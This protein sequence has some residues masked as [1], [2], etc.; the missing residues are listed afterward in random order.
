MNDAIILVY[1]S[2]SDFGT[3]CFA[4]A[5]VDNGIALIEDLYVD[6]GSELFILVTSKTGS[7]DYTLT[8]DGLDCN[9]VPAPTG[10]TA[11][12][13][14]AGDFLSSLQVDG[15]VYNQGFTW[16]S[17]AALTNEIIDPDTELL[18]D[19]TTYYVTQTIL[20][21]ES[22]ALAITA[23]EFDCSY[24]S[25]D[26]LTPLVELCLPGGEVTLHAVVNAGD[27]GRWIDSDTA[28]EPITKTDK[29]ELGF[30][31]TTVSYWV[32]EVTLGGTG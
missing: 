16:Y 3:Q 15:S 12:F 31:D 22:D 30:V 28:V 2:C 26:I 10:D 18:V 21:C 4:S 11:P 7:F 14:I 32:S 1:E 13:F 6:A 29:L 24:L 19:N 9:N 27:H 17:D 5:E 25:P 20:G 8:I 23:M